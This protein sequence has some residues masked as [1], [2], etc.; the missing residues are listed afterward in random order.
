M[1]PVMIMTWR[2]MLRK[3]ALLVTLILTVAFLFLYWL[4]VSHVAKSSLRFS[5]RSLLDTYIQGVSFLAAG[6]FFANFV[7]AYLMIF[8]SAGAIS[9][10]IENGILLSILPRPVARWQ[11]YLGKWCG[12]ALWGLLYGGVLFWSLLLIVHTELHYPL[13]FASLGRAFALLEL[14]PL[15]LLTLTLLGSSYLPVLGNGVAVTLLFGLGMLGGLLEQFVGPRDTLTGEKIGLVTSLLVPTDS[16][17]RRMVY[18]MMGGGSLPLG[19]H[20]MRM[21]GPFASTAVPSNAFLWYTA[22]YI[23]VIGIWG[24]VHF[25]RRDI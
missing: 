19:E 18:E 10:E 12:Y 14:I 6:L 15:V 22:C 24:C 16:L 20:A 11:V 25:S 8:S 4:A 23:L 7:L 9:G 2:E 17:Y 5:G 13:D 21:L 3:R 1:I